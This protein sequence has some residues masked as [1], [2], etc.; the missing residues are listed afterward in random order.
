[1][2][3]MTRAELLTQG[4]LEANRDD[5]VGT[6]VRTWL[7]TWLK[8]TAKS[9][10]WPKLKRPFGSIV[11]AAGTDSLTVGNGSGGITPVLHRLVGNIILWRNAAYTSQ[12]TI[13]TRQLIDADSTK[14]PRTTLAANRRGTPTTAKV[15][16]GVDDTS[17][18]GKFIIEPD[19]VPSVTLCLAFD[20]H[21][22]P[23]SI[24]AT[25]ATD[26]SKP[27]YPSDRTLADAVKVAFLA[28]E[29][30]GQNLPGFVSA[31]EH[32]DK[33][34]VADRDF[35]GEGPGDNQMMGLDQSVFR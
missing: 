15:R 17:D 1:M 5:D 26:S 11:L 8:R 19:P 21:V 16:V 4:G 23:A 6:F 33:L 9:W 3:T 2:G 18:E 7:D 34:V 12:G 29:D 24:G 14:D 25:S 30:Q 32:L 35:D 22:I 31:M 13:Y 28:L 27:W 10:S 20:A